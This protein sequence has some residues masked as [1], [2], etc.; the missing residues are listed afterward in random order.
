MQS[1]YQIL[2]QISIHQCD[3]QIINIL[4][5]IDALNIL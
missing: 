5:F 4:Q 1:V 2:S 3:S